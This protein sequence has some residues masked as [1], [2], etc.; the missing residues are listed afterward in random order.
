MPVDI[1]DMLKEKE[2]EMEAL[3]NEAKNKASFIREEA[4]KRAK[5]IKAAELK[6]MDAEIEA[7]KAMEEARIMEEVSCFEAKAKEE[8]EGFKRSEEGKRARAIKEAVRII[9]GMAAEGSDDRED[10]KGSDNRTQGPSR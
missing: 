10:D 1:L 2:K 6:E 4:V 3:I 7:L 8:A 5:E 9:M